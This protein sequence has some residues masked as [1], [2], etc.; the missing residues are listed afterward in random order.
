MK[1]TAGL[2]SQGRE[3]TQL[4]PVIEP[5][6]VLLLRTTAHWV[7]ARQAASVRLA[8]GASPCAQPSVQMWPRACSLTIRPGPRSSRSQDSDLSLAALPGLERHDGM[9]AEAAW[10]RVLILNNIDFGM[11]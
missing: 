8:I 9:K 3:M 10:F 7:N 11:T 1:E 2:F 6:A 5:S 4:R